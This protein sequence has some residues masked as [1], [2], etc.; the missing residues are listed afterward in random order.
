M[1]QLIVTLISLPLIAFW[2]WMFWHMANRETLPQCFITFTSGSNSRFD[3]TVAFV[4]L[5]IL[6]AIVYYSWV[7]RNKY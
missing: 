6:T 7:Y 1:G 4:F 2:L 3:W 5:S